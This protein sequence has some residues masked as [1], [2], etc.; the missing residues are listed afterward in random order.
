[1]VSAVTAAFFDSGRQ[2]NGGSCRP[3]AIV[4]LSLGAK[5]NNFGKPDSREIPLKNE[6]F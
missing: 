2:A 1:M 4:D 6:D 5:F 3:A